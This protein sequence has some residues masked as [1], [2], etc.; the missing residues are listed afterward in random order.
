ME[1]KRGRR[2]VSKLQPLS[3]EGKLIERIERE[4]SGKG[5]IYTWFSLLKHRKQW[6][7]RKFQMDP[8][9]QLLKL[10]KGMKEEDMK[11]DGPNESYYAF[12]FEQVCIPH[13]NEL[14]ISVP[15]NNFR[16]ID[17]V[18]GFKFIKFKFI[19]FSIKNILKLFG[20]GIL[21][22]LIYTLLL[23]YKFNIKRS[24]QTYQFIS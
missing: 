15:E 2:N 16:N 17:K 18:F 4:E 9:N 7:D 20:I 1:R 10:L 3:K 11:L 13:L 5:P 21:L 14:Q 12:L 6:L 8:M 23:Y 19:K 24:N 22:S